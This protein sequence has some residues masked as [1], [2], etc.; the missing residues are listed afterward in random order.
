MTALTSIRDGL[1]DAPPSWC[2]RRRRD[3]SVPPFARFG[4]GSQI[5]WPCTVTAPDCIEIGV[6]VQLGDRTWL[7]LTRG[8]D[9]QVTQDGVPVQLFDPRLTI[10]DRTCFGRDLTVACLGRVSIGR[11]VLGGDRILI[12]DTFH[13]YRDPD[14]PIAAQPMAAPR[15]VTIGD[16]AFLGT[17]VVV[18]PGVTIGAG[19][20]IAA[21]SVVTRDV[22]PC[23]H[24][25]GSPAR[26]IRRY[27]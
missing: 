1:R 16:G 5:G 7:A 19:A 17:A 3:R 26:E 18:N 13:D 27:A 10:G 24:V 2:T 20:V 11:D 6:G 25:A 8:R 14:T 15:A 22:A 23:A 21:G 4:A 9:A 12:A